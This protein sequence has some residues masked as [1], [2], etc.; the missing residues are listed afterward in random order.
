MQE[1]KL[2]LEIGKL[3]IEAEKLNEELRQLRVPFYKKPA[4]FGVFMPVVVTLV[5]GLLNYKKISD[6]Q[7]AEDARIAKEERDNLL[8]ERLRFETIML[9]RNK[10]EIEE[11]IVVKQAELDSEKKRVGS[12]QR[13]VAGLTSD[14]EKEKADSKRK[15]DSIQ[16][17]YEGVIA[18]Y[19][20]E[21]QT[22]EERKATQAQ[23]LTVVTEQVKQTNEAYHEIQQQVSNLNVKGQ[24]LT[25]VSKDLKGLMVR[26]YTNWNKDVASNEHERLRNELISTRDELKRLYQQMESNDYKD[27]FES[28][29]QAIGSFIDDKSAFKKSKLMQ[30]IPHVEDINKKS[31]VL[32]ERMQKDV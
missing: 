11:Q 3:R 7:L 13:R 1:E 30:N 5:I 23:E 12:F 18:R 14:L 32:I 31:D 8:Q 16:S 26:F 21:I 6:E 25:K 27:E 4:Y 2:Q 20:N 29:D 22:L 19:T 10:E 24:L 28:M 15:R 9:A 17:V